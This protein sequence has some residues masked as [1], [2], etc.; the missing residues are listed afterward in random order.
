MTNVMQYYVEHFLENNAISRIE[1]LH[2]LN[3][4]HPARLLCDLHL[5]LCLLLLPFPSPP[6]TDS[7]VGFLSSC[8]I[9][10]MHLFHAATAIMSH[11]LLSPYAHPS[12]W[13][14]SC[15]LFVCLHA[16]SVRRH[17]WVLLGP[18]SNMP[19]FISL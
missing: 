7:T 11:H 6:C 3:A 2:V 12:S 13:A 9:D 5:P 1:I 16:R 15:L 19:G 8:L 17:C 10:S 4:V 14:F 18:D